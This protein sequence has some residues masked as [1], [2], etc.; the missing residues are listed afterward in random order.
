MAVAAAVLFPGVAAPIRNRCSISAGVTPARRSSARVTTPCA[1]VPI[2][3]NT[4]CT[5]LVC[6]ATA[7][8]PYPHPN[9]KS[10]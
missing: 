9:V 7:G 3:P 5:V 10:R 6:T 4:C 2:P 8:A 1:E